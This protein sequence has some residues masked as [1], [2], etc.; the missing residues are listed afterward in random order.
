M[1]IKHAILYMAGVAQNAPLVCYYY[2]FQKGLPAIDYNV[3]IYVKSSIVYSCFFSDV[4]P[5][6][7]LLSVGQK[8]R[9]ALAR[10]LLRKPKV[11][12]LD[13]ATSS[14]DL[15]SEQKVRPLD[16]L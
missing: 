5:K 7:G 12:I 2:L 8:Q 4:G 9:V 13:D 10:A 6:G 1:T 11:L 15:E 3:V 14:L 16:V